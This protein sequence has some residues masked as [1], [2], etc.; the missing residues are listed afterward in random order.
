MQE[1]SRRTVLKGAAWAAPAIAAT[2]ASPLLA[3][4][5]LCEDAT[6]QKR[7]VGVAPGYAGAT[8]KVTVPAQQTKMLIWI[9]GGNGGGAT[10]CGRGRYVHAMVDVTPGDVFVLQAGGGGE[11]NGKKK[12]RGGTSGF[13]QGGR[14][15]CDGTWYGGGGGGASAI[16]TTSGKP[17]IVAGGGGGDNI[18][19]AKY[20]SPSGV[21]KTY[22]GTSTN[23][24]PQH[25]NIPSGAGHGGG[26]GGKGIA[27]GYGWHKENE[28]KYRI[29]TTGGAGGSQTSGG[30]GGVVKVINA[31]AKMH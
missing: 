17:L 4:T 23:A 31:G 3:A 16:V 26:V 10:N 28:N 14:G 25:P 24:V 8:L 12:G 30:A 6:S 20:K 5:D 29:V 18:H 27:G 1:T 2:A 11:A 21:S 9:V 7:V 19:F 15:G 13:A 22:W